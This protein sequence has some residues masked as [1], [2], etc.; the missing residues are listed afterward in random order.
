MAYIIYAISFNT[1]KFR[2]RFNNYNNWS[3]IIIN[4]MYNK[5]VF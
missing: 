4:L 2:I 1:Y 3:N 5:F